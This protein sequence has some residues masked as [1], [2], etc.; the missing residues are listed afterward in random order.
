MALRQLVVFGASL[1]WA[2][3]GGEGGRLVAPY[4][5]P[6]VSGPRLLAY[7]YRQVDDPHGVAVAWVSLPLRMKGLQCSIR[8]RLA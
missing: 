6:F 7:E 4:F 3:L 8:R 1:S 2:G 5:G